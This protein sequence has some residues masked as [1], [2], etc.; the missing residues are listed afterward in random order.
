[1]A[2]VPRTIGSAVTGLISFGVMVIGWQFL[3][4]TF[5][6]ALRIERIMK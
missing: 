1:M 2:I 5:A 6:P 4:K 3:A